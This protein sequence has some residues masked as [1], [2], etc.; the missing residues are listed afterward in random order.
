MLTKRR[1]VVL[2]KKETQIREKNE[3][4]SLVGAILNVINLIYNYT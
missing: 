3:L 1:N 4:S 2:T